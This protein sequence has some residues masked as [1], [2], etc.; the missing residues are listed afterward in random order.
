M[1]EFYWEMQFQDSTIEGEREVRQEK[2]LQS[3]MF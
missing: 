3:G 1:L 2:Q